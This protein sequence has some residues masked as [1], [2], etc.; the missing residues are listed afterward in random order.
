[1]QELDLRV[2]ELRGGYHTKEVVHGVSFGAKAGDVLAVLGPNGCGKSTLLKLVLRFLPPMGGKIYTRGTEVGAMGRRELAQVFAYIP[3]NENMS[4]PY[5]AHE[6]VTMARTNRISGFSS[7][8]KADEAAALAAL[9]ELQIGHLANHYY[10]M[11]SGGQQQLVL[12][13][14]ALCQNACIMVMDEPTANLD[15]ANQKLVTSAI[16]AIASTGKIVMITTHSPS[17]PFAVATKTLLMHEGNVA[18]FGP[19]A[20]VLTPAVLEEV[21]G[22]PMDVV[23]VR[24]RTQKEH[25]ICLS[26]E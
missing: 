10:N 16:K 9:Q 20:D 12:I 8:S 3:Q 14:R 25:R 4:F 21:Y 15:F 18:G 17:Q 13:A 24:D 5:T 2:E 11:L 22:L 19:P 7:P 1:M 23:S 26:I 6:M